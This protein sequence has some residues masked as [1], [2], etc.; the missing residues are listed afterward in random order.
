MNTTNS[1]H[2]IDQIPIAI[3]KVII[4]KLVGQ[5]KTISKSYVVF[6]TRVV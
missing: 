1:N 5:K 6:V 3:R 2:N 4:Q